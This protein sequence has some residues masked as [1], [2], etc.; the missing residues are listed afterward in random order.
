SGHV[1]NF[2]DPLVECKNCHQRFRADHVSGPRHQEDGGEFTE[3]R[4]FNLMFKTFIGPLE[5]SSTQVYLRPE[6]AQDSFVN[7]HNVTNS[8]RMRPPFGIAQIG[9]AFRKVITP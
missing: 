1:Q 7:S 6:T 9:K 4:Q 2:T 8:T 5:N 3:A